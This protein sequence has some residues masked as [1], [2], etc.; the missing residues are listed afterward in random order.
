MVPNNLTAQLSSFIG[1]KREIGDVKRL[2]ATTRLLTLTGSGGT[3]KTRLALQVAADLLAAQVFNDGVWLVEL[4]PLSDPK[5][6][7]QAI[8]S[9]LNVRE[10][11]GTPLSK[12]LSDFLQ[13]EHFLLILDNCEHLID[14]C[15]LFADSMLR[16]APQLQILATSREALGI[17]GETVWRVPGLSMPDPQQLPF[18]M[19]EAASALVRYDAIRLFTDRAAAVLPS[20][21]LSND[22]APVVAQ[23]CGRLDGIPLAIELAAARVKVLS[24]E[25]IAT[26]LDDRFRLLTYGNRAALPR[27][28]TLQAAIDWSYDLLSEPERVL[29]R[30]LSVF[31]GGFTLEA[32]ERVMSDEWRVTRE[33]TRHPSL[34]TSDVFD[35]LSRLVDKSLVLVGEQNESSVARYQLLETI[36]AY[37]LEKLNASGETE[38]RRQQHAAYYLTLAESAEAQLTGPQQE[39]WLQRLEAEHDNL[40]AAL[41]WTLDDHD[42][43]RQPERVEARVRFV[44]AL[45]RFWHV[46]GYLSE[47]R[48][49][50]ER[51]VSGSA[52]A[53]AAMLAKALRGLGGIAWAQGDYALARSAQE[54]SLSLY[55]EIG[56]LRGVAASLN[57]LAVIAIE[58]ADLSSAR[59]LFEQS[60]ALRRTLADQRDVA[61]SLNNLAVVAREQ[62]DYPSASTFLEESL[63]ICREL[64]FK[65]GIASALNTLG[66]VSYVLGHY[67]LARAQLAES[68]T[69]YH[70]LG[71]K[72]DVAECLEGL[73]GVAAAQKQ[74][75]HAARWFGLAEALREMIGAPV[76]AALRAD[77][78]RDVATTRAQLDELTF[79]A[80][81]AEGKAMK[82]EQAIKEAME[83]A[84]QIV[85]ERLVAQPPELAVQEPAKETVMPPVEVSEAAV[86]RVYA[87][88]RARVYVNDRLL[89]SSDWA[90]AKAKEL[91][92]YLLANPPK[93][94]EQIG[95][96]LWPDASP[97]QLRSSFHR[98]AHYVRRAL[99]R[100]EWII[101]EKETYSFNRSLAYWFDLED[102]ERHLSESRRALRAQP[103]APT[104]AMYS[105]HQAIK[106]YEGDFLDDLVEG[107][108]HLTRREELRR[109]CLEA[110]LTLAQLYFQQEHYIQAAEIYHQAIAHDNYLEAAHRGLMRCYARLGD[111]GQA[112]RHYQSL[113]TLMQNELGSPPAPETKALFE[114]LRRGENI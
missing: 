114:H 110:L 13:A 28:Q 64:K 78:E 11:P 85:A 81:W 112:L 76:Q 9:A 101:V 63:A 41:L 30:R 24:V 103:K 12:T 96:A 19:E 18:G 98:T 42:R 92:F 70:E 77:Y 48:Q 69:V 46:R 105:L 57:N 62:G 6:V 102:F 72:R 83:P 31:A 33:D 34:V 82:L 26:R 88:G 55:R 52:G 10:E 89:T 65:Q 44:G 80:A 86:L 4:A 100:P 61:S 23:I 37:A 49:W 1:R 8:A 21:A 109:I 16:A 84:A 67:Q 94:R 50:L 7:H 53:S 95:L 20:F 51:A 97:D 87:L 60:L 32:A 15:A 27:H 39:L 73:A 79:A 3:G 68:L 90:Y 104:P 66:T 71:Y 106:L 54:E 43:A 2:L 91:L 111:H 45:W 35:L 17:A 47:G 93:T 40:R 38:A 14:A 59:S 107:E 113:V 74:P 5:L 56:N 99:G 36:R 108:W 25:Q 58:Q 22:N 75:M 29:L